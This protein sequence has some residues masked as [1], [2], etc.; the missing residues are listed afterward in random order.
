M[1]GV[2]CPRK[3]HARL[4]LPPK[5]LQRGAG[6]DGA[7]AVPAGRLCKQSRQHCHSIAASTGIALVLYHASGRS[8]LEA[9]PVLPKRDRALPRCLDPLVPGASIPRGLAR[10]RRSWSG[11]QVAC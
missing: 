10:C 2:P 7:Q 4:A 6:T 3:A 9:F 8:C 1:Q 11:Q 5:H